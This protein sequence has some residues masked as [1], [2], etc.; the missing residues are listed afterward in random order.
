MGRH[1]TGKPP[2]QPLLRVESRHREIMR[3]LISGESNHRI[4]ID[5]GMSESRLSIIRNSPLFIKEYKKLEAEVKSRFV[6]SSAK[7][8]EKINELQEPAIDLLGRLLKDKSVEDLRVTPM[9]KHQV[10][11]DLLELG[12]NGKKRV[13]NNKNDAINDVIKVISDGFELAKQALQEKVNA[14]KFAATSSETK[15]EA[16]EKHEKVL[17]SIEDIEFEDVTEDSSSSNSTALITQPL[18]NNLQ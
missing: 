2:D 10:A 3:R 1:P 11:L 4:S 7:V 14:A 8:Q 17:H 5:L 16:E 12:G 15:T 13:E 9:L 6:D 18:S